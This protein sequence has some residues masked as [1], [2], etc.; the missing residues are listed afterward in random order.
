VHGSRPN[1]AG[2]PRLGFV[3]TY[4]AP[5]TQMFGPRTGATLVRGTDTHG[6]FD[7]ED[8][9]PP[10]DLD[11]DCLRAHARA[12][13]PMAAAIYTGSAQEARLSPTRIAASDS[14]P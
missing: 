6:H 12:T 4:M 14:R 2:G 10:R 8:V 11:P 7:L 9:R 1:R 5:A 13:A 3:V